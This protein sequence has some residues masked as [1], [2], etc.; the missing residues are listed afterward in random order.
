[1]R[2]AREAEKISLARPTAT[3]IQNLT[4]PENWLQGRDSNP[5]AL[6]VMSVPIYQLNY[7]AIFAT[8]AA[9]EKQRT[10]R[11]NQ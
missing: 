2:E 4:R 9:I 1:V 10:R 7:P 11:I 6:D 5:R 8:C 3:A